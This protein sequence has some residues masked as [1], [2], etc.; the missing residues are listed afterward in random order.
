MLTQRKVLKN[1]TP[2][3]SQKRVENFN[4]SI[5]VHRF[6]RSDTRKR[7]RERAAMGGRERN[8]RTGII[9]ACV[10][11]CVSKVCAREFKKTFINPWARGLIFVFV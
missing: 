5:E 3:A 2:R 11:V 7:E 1:L 10:C 9:P 6:E 4:F 8:A